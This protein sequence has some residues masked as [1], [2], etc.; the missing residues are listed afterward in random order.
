MADTDASR[1]SAERREGSNPSPRTCHCG[2]PPEDYMHY[3]WHKI[4][5]WNSMVFA[6]GKAKA[7]REFD[8]LL[9]ERAAARRKK[10]PTVQRGDDT[11]WRK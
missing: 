9:D 4:H 1:A 10:V 2:M 6:D 3:G 7:E 5:D 11:L 8:A